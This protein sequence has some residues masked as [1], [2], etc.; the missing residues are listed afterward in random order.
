VGFLLSILMMSFAWEGA[1]AADAKRVMLLHSM[2][3]DSKP[4]SAYARAIRTELDQQSPWPLDITEHSLL[5]ARSSD[6]NP[7]G[8]FVQYLRAT[9]SELPLD[10]IVSIGA[11]A[12]AFVQRHRHELFANTP[13]VF[14]AVEQ[15]RI[16]RSSLTENDTVVAIAQNFPAI[17]ENIRHVL[18]DTTTV[19]V[20]I[21]NSPLERLWLE[22]LRKEFAPFADRL[23]F[24]WYN[25]QSFGGILKR[26]AS[27][28]PHSAIYWHQMNVDAAGAVHVGDKGL[29][30]L[31]AVANAPIFSYTD[32]FFGGGVV[33]GPMNSV[34]EAS[35]QTVAV[36]IRILGGEKAGDI[37]IPPIGFA[38]PKFDWREMQ[39]WGISERRLPPGSEILFREPS[40]WE[41]YR[42]QMTSIFLALLV[43]F[44]MIAWLLMERHRRRSAELESRRRLLQVVHLNRSAEAGA[45][46]AAFAHDLNQPLAAIMLHADSVERLLDG[47]PKDDR[48]ISKLADIRE[49]AQHGADITRHLR[50]L[51][52]HQSEAEVE[53][54]DF[55]EVLA[56]AVSILAPEAAKRR[57]TLRTD[58]VHRPLLV[59]AD[60]IHLQ[61]VILNLAINAMDAMADTAAGDRIITIQATLP[62]ESRLEVSV[63]DS[64][65]GI[66]DDKLTAVFDTFYTTKKDGTGLGLS[67]VRTIVETY[68]GK[69]WAHNRP[70]GG[71][72]FR[73][74][75]PLSGPHIPARERTVSEPVA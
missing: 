43:Q 29:Q 19:A 9:Y 54:F 22:T 30:T 42:W 40:A 71:A 56:D 24:I 18:P 28:P 36:A 10:L 75:L 3:P 37:K 59:R 4:W 14:T 20:V 6:K 45:L 58:G 41:R 11:P 66:P 73:F 39:R 38:T 62:E 63:I 25:D 47:R 16:Q 2:G 68:G 44:A 55:R 12:A 32:V 46:S 53:Q 67:I 21:G 65:P 17:I 72:V 23:S 61:Q 70:D 8:P 52:K 69:I 34:S 26:A 51:M 13:M 48:L 1:S 27:L 50:M 60:R 5:T 7:E 31:Y 15:R 49:A 57:V 33:G 35:R 64:G 74:T